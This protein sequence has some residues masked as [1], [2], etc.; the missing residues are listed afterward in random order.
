MRA[1]NEARRE[2]LKFTPE[3][4]KKFEEIVLKEY[5]AG[6]RSGP[7]ILTLGWLYFQKVAMKLYDDRD[8]MI[9]KGREAADKAHELMGDAN[10][11]V[12]GAWF[13]LFERDYD[14]AQEKVRIAS[15]IGS[16]FG[17]DLAVTGTVYLLSGKPELA[18]Q[19]FV[20]AMRTSPFHP[21][22]YA[23]RLVTCLILLGRYDEAT[24]VAQSI[25]KKG[26]QGKITPYAYARALVSLA[27]IAKRK[28][29]DEAGRNII[30]RLTEVN[31]NFTQKTL[32]MY[33]GQM[34]DKSI[35]EDFRNILG[36]Y[37]LPAGG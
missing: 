32:G 12:L 36:D 21:P 20:D 29:D 15:N 22:W 19:S 30:K 6:S 5:E 4:H 1:L 27:V 14:A 9:A 37:G 8:Q 16:P 34:R 33:I 18:R 2:M 35:I 7:V 13:D 10:S 3:A 17:D 25:V 11:L 26:E 31:P 24:K 28:K 23:N